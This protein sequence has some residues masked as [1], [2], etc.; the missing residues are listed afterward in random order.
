MRVWSLPGVYAAAAA[1]AVAAAERA[2]LKKLKAKLSAAKAKLSVNPKPPPKQAKA[3]RPAQTGRGDGEKAALEVGEQVSVLA[4]AWGTD[5]A[6]AEHPQDW[7]TARVSGTVLEET[8]EGLTKKFV[9]DFGEKDGEKHGAFNRKALQFESRPSAGA[10][11]SSEGQ[12]NAARKKR[13]AAGCGRAPSAE[14][15]KN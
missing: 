8:M 9:C 10:G 4:T 3:G 11:S 13:G 12:S 2:A 15:A 6:K 14:K 7:K 5:W 1:E